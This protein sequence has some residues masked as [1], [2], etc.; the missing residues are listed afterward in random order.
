MW[1][2]HGF[3]GSLSR[4]RLLL[5]TVYWSETAVC[6]VVGVR[7][8]AQAGTRASIL[9]T[10][11][12]IPLLFSNRL[13]FAADILG[14]VANLSEAPWFPWCHGL[15]SS[16]IACSYL[17]FSQSSSPQRIFSILWFSSELYSSSHPNRTN[18]EAGWPGIW[19]N[20]TFDMDSA[21]FLRIFSQVSF[22]SRPPY[23]VCPVEVS[24][25]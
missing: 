22:S 2:R 17:S 12:L 25:C 8:L 5:T 7:T 11:Y 6:N 21:S 19:H 18:H 4:W 24:H 23:S 15:C 9:S 13:S 10:I 20:R 3:I 1:K 14:L 16:I